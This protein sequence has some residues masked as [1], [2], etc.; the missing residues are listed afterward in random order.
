MDIASICLAISA[1][2]TIQ[3]DRSQFH[4]YDSINLSCAVPPD[5]G[6]WTLRRNTSS[7]SSEPC[8]SG[9]GKTRDPSSCTIQNAYLFDSGVYWCQSERGECSNAINLT[10]TSGTVILWIS[11]LPVT[12]GD[13][14]VLLCQYKEEDNNRAT[15][16][17]YANF[18]KDGA[19]IGTHASGKMTLP[20]VSRSDEGLYMCEHP[21]EGQS[22][23]SWL[24]VSSKVGAQPLPPPPPPPRPPLMSPPRLVY[25]I[26]LIILHTV[27]LIV[28]VSVYKM[29]A[30]AR[31]EVK[32]ASEH[33]SLG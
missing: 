33:L 2:L 5:S 18:Y 20:S 9:W 25:T 26:L 30:K 19:F 31:A 32:R 4:H 3:L 8:K 23:Q 27:M 16:N 21:T 29:W 15:S 17:F 11:A 22:P 10:V 7:R 14:V 1:T 28:C 24:A 12:E 13:E 6:V